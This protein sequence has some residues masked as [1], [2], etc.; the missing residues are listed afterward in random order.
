MKILGLIPARGGSKGIPGKNIKYLGGKPLLSYTFEAAAKSQLLSKIILSS[1]SEEIIQV[2][3]SIGLEVPFVRPLELAQDNT[4]SI[5]VII[6]ALN[7]YLA[8]G[9]EF[10][11]VCLLQPTSPLR[12][13]KLI[14]LAIKKFIH[15]GND[16]LVT[17]KK[18]PDEFNPHWIFEERQGHL[19]IATGE[20]KIISRR[21]DLPNA[22]FRDGAVYITKSEIILKDQSLYGERIGYLDTT[23]FPYINIDTPADWYEAEKLINSGH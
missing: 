13:D 8:Q 22:F 2:A 5:K 18:V 19:F 9:E 15:G 20:K 4:P 17:V 14:D 16:S 3:K 1:E 10:D 6:H 11:A 12:Q 21:Q 7:F 23:G